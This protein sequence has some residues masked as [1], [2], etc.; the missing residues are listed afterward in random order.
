MNSLRQVELSESTVAES[1]WFSPAT[2]VPAAAA[3]APP[4]LGG[5]YALSHRVGI[6]AD[7]EIHEALDTTT[8]RTVDVTLFR[9]GSVDDRAAIHRVRSEAELAARLSHPNI[10]R[11]VDWGADSDRLY[12]V[13]ESVRGETLAELL[14]N[15]GPLA[16][17][18]AAR[19]GADVAAGLAAGRAQGATHHQLDA[20]AVVITGSGMVKVTG[21]SLDVGGDSA[22]GAE[23]A[24]TDLEQ[25]GT[26]LHAMVDVPQ[27]VQAA[28]PEVLDALFVDEQRSGPDGGTAPGLRAIIDRLLATAPGAGYPSADAAES[29]LRGYRDDPMPA[30]ERPVPSPAQPSVPPVEQ[31]E[32]VTSS[33]FFLVGLAALLLVMIGA[34]VYLSNAISGSENTATGTIGVPTVIGDPSDVA[35]EQLVAAGFLVE[36]ELVETAE[37]DAGTVFAQNPPP[38]TEM[39]GGETITISIAQAPS[40]VVVP[41]VVDQSRT[42]AVDQLSALGL[43]VQLRRETSEVIAADRVISQSLRPG[44]EVDDGSRIT[45]VVSSGPERV[46][47]PELAG[48]TVTQATAVLE[49]QSL[50]NVR[51]EYEWSESVPEDAII[52]TEPAAGT[53]IEVSAPITV[54]VSTGLN[55]FVPGVVGLDRGEAER[56]IRQA[57]FEPQLDYVKVEGD[58]GLVGYVIAQ[59]PDT[60]TL[61]PIGS[62]IW[63]QVGQEDQSLIDRL[64]GRGDDGDDDRRGNRGRGRDRDD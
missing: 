21:F 43:D 37:H 17:A 30:A 11:T 4:L 19:I 42:D 22:R 53:E 51:W 6:D 27:P 18:R 50:S 10:V 57:G 15:E 26:L 64:L 20:G 46:A 47:V 63:I 34:A 39:N 12:L 58:S 5:R 38:R 2:E 24:P 1:R 35:V 44:D 14:A 25:L 23:P 55:N 16:A 31:P 8:D 61:Q 45:V 36:E 49:E 60:G 9:P 52:S 54:V 3:A 56:L 62:K 48:L 59:G 41:D 33:P 40:T 28:E 7:G 13:R 32:N 29:D